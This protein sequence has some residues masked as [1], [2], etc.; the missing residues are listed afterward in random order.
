MEGHLF[1]LCYCVLLTA[2]FK[3]RPSANC[4]IDLCVQVGREG[5]WIWIWIQVQ[6]SKGFEFDENWIFFSPLIGVLIGD[7]YTA[8]KVNMPKSKG[9][10]AVWVQIGKK[11]MPSTLVGVL[12]ITPNTR[13]VYEFQQQTL[14]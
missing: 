8:M 6:Y 1:L 5:A 11:E 7:E 2:F 3:L 12:Y 14:D 9:V 13:N 4:L 10:E